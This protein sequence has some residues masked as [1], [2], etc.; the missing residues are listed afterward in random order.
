MIK[1]KLRKTAI[2][3]SV[4]LCSIAFLA[5]VLPYFINVCTNHRFHY[6]I[7]QMGV[8]TQTHYQ[9][10]GLTPDKKYSLHLLVD[11]WLG[12][13]YRIEATTRFSVKYNTVLLFAEEHFKVPP[14]PL[15]NRQSPVVS[16]KDSRYIALIASGWYVDCY[17]FHDVTGISPNPRFFMGDYSLK[18]NEEYFQKLK[19]YHEKIANIIGEDPISIIEYNTK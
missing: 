18:E 17:D 19:N 15:Q 10:L 12:T 11:S 7:E 13:V 8:L 5:F 3:T 4:I 6:S 14:G 1:A 9:N 16:S 2:V